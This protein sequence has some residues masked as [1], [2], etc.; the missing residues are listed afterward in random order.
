MV[1]QLR[2]DGINI[3]RMMDLPITKIKTT[4]FIVGPNGTESVD[5]SDG[6]LEG[7][8]FE[9]TG[10]PVFHLTGYIIEHGVV[11]PE[12]APVFTGVPSGGGS[13]LLALICWVAL[14]RRRSL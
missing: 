2:C 12:P 5:T 13:T 1:T 10:S 8:F 3:L 4:V 7:S 6:V 11:I 9:T 14:R